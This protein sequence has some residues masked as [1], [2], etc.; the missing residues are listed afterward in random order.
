MLKRRSRAAMALLLWLALLLAAVGCA[1][2]GQQDTAQSF[3]SFTDDAG[4]R[5]VLEEILELGRWRQEDC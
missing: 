1:G 4:R 5:V 3:Y 2:E